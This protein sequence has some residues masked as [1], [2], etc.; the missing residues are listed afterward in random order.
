M[1]AE[2]GA[3]L[4]GL[5]SGQRLGSQATTTRAGAGRVAATVRAL[6][7]SGR[8]DLTRAG[9]GRVSA[10]VCTL[11]SALP[12]SLARKRKVSPPGL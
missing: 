11:L 6:L 3:C 12:S 4:L 5:R 7:V 9:S 8:A 1:L 10:R 2:H